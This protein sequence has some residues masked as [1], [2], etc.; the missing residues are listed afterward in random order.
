MQYIKIVTDLSGSVID[1]SAV[2]IDNLFRGS[3]IVCHLQANVLFSGPASIQYRFTTNPMGVCT[4]LVSDGDAD[5]GTQHMQQ[6]I[7]VQLQNT[8]I[9]F[10]SSVDVI[11]IKVIGDHGQTISNITEALDSYS[12]SSFNTTLQKLLARIDSDCAITVLND[13]G[14][15]ISTMLSNTLA[16]HAVRTAI[17]QSLL[18]H[19]TGPIFE[20]DTDKLHTFDFS[21]ISTAPPIALE[22]IM[23]NGIPAK[24]YKN[25]YL[26]SIRLKNISIIL[27]ATTAADN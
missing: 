1:A 6:Y 19:I 23:E 14:S 18:L 17:L 7:N 24:I 10:A 21:T 16:D 27:I 25:E 20:I 9:Q 3:K 8:T 11:P 2:P 26:R 13:I 22:F 4:G 12:P 5:T 15:L